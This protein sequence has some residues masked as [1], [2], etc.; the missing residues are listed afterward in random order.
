ML[1]LIAPEDREYRLKK[2]IWCRKKGEV[3]RPDAYSPEYVADLR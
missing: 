1:P 2:G 3:L